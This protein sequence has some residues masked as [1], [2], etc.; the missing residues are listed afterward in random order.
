MTTPPATRF[1]DTALVLGATVRMI[2]FATTDALGGAL[3]R[4]PL[5]TLIEKR[6]PEPPGEA[7]E[8][9]DEFTLAHKEMLRDG[10]YCPFCIGMWVGT[11]VLGTYAVAT[12]NPRALRAWRFVA[13]SLTLNEVAGHI[14]ARLDGGE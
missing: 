12:R 5:L 10:L 14:S 7:V 1:L 13:A 11:A 3:I 4:V 2:R 8:P 9:L 6:Y